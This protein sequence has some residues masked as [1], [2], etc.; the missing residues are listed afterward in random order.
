MGEGPDYRIA[1]RGVPAGRARRLGPSPKCYQEVLD[2]M[3]NPFPASPR[4]PPRVVDVGLVAPGEARGDLLLVACFEGEAPTPSRLPP[5]ARELTGRLAARAGWKGSAGQAAEGDTGD[6]AVP[7][8][9]L[10]GLGKRDALHV[11]KLEK[12]LREATEHASVHAVEHLLL[13]LPEHPLTTGAPATGRL[14]RQLAAARYRFEQF[15]KPAEQPETLA[16]V[17]LL[18]EAVDEDHRHA[19]AVAMEAA[20]GMA[21][22]RDLANTPPNVATPE[23]IAER[24]EELAA[25]LG[26]GSRC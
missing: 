14:A 2:A 3:A 22:A 26:L 6:P 24:A 8:V 11:R 10:R 18:L 23:W 4:T 16:R 13:A 5:A 15:R 7:R 25:E 20:R 1:V 21:A 19:L 12:W 17:D 9:A